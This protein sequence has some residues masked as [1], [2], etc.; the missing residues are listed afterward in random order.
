MRAVAVLLAALALAGC[1]AP[2][3]A[4]VTP[5][6]ALGPAAADGASATPA[7]GPA[8]QRAEAPTARAAA[9]VGE[10]VAMEVEAPDGT[11]LRGHAYLPDTPPPHAVVLGFGPYWG[12]LFPATN[13]M[14]TEEGGLQ[15][16]L[17]DVAYDALLRAGFAVALFNVRGTGASGGCYRFFDP[18]DGTDGARVVEALAAQPWSDGRIGMYG[19]SYDG[20]TQYAAMAAGAPLR[21]TAPLSGILDVWSAHA[22][23]GATA[24]V[25]VGAGTYYA[26]SVAGVERWCAEGATDTTGVDVAG[27]HG[28]RTEA[29]ARR[30]LRAGVAGSGIPAFVT[31]GLARPQMIG[32]DGRQP[33]FEGLVMNAA[34][35]RALPNGSAVLVGPWGHGPPPVEELPALLVAW[36]DHHLRGGARPALPGAR[37][38]DDEGG[39]HEADA[40]PPPTA[41]LTLA[42]DGARTLLSTDRPPG[43]ALDAPDQASWSWPAPA[44]GALLAGQFLLRVDVTSSATDGNFAAYLFARRGAELVEL[45]RAHTDLRHRGHLE[46]GEPFPVGRA[47]EIEVASAPFAA[48]LRSG[49]EVVLVVSGGDGVELAPKAAKPLL[50]VSDGALQLPVVPD[51]D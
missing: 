36:F 21:A 16:I 6:A 27:L 28:D 40:W 29:L 44:G 13:A 46:Q 33:P 42:L 17:D 7:T 43:W 45:A 4:P 22:R 23:N 2:A 24:R 49:D 37:Y 39:W 12:G 11:A 30:D 48:R 5:D 3:P 50:T 25:Y 15:R 51:A 32:A 34:D 20:W 8:E 31:Y 9:K 35:L 38:Q 47:A 26:A 1:A 18:Q 14:A 41:P 19:V 10:V